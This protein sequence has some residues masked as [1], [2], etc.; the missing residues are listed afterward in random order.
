MEDDDAHTTNEKERAKSTMGGTDGSLSRPNCI[1]YTIEE[2]EAAT[3]KFKPDRK[4]GEGGYGPV[5]KCYLNNTPVAIK[6]LRP[7][8][9]HGQSQ[10]NQ[11]VY[12]CI[13]II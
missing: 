13:L 2:I 6:T 5:Y 11:E 8:A 1:R 10:F 9:T 12:I 4:I 7:D 3:D